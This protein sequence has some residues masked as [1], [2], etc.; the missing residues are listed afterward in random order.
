MDVI[1]G[2]KDETGRLQIQLERYT[3]DNDMLRRDLEQREDTI[4]VLRSKLTS[5]QRELD[6]MNQNLAKDEEE[7]REK[8]E[9]VRALRSR[10]T[11]LEQEL[12]TLNAEKNNAL[13]DGD[14]LRK[15]KEHADEQ[16]ESIRNQSFKARADV[17]TSEVAKQRLQSLYEGAVK[18]TEFLKKDNKALE[19][20]LYKLKRDVLDSET[21]CNE[22]FNQ[23]KIAQE[24]EKGLEREIELTQEKFSNKLEE[25][26]KIDNIRLETERANFDLQNQNQSLKEQIARDKKLREDIGSHETERVRLLRRIDELELLLKDKAEQIV[27]ITEMADKERDEKLRLEGKMDRLLNETSSIE[28]NIQRARE[29]EAEYD[30]LL[31]ELDM[32]KEKEHGLIKENEKLLVDNKRH[33]NLIANGT[34]QIEHVNLQKEELQREIRGLKE[35]VSLY[36]STDNEAK[37]RSI[38]L[39]EKLNNHDIL[40]ADLRDSKATEERKNV[41]LSD[42]ITNL[43][44]D[45]AQEKSKNEQLTEQIKQLKTL[46]EGLDRTREELLVRLQNKNNER[47]IEES[48]R[49]RL[50]EEINGLKRRLAAAEQDTK[51]SRMAMTEIDRER[52]A[53]QNLLDEKS[54]S[55]EKLR[56]RIES[57]E[58]ELRTMKEKSVEFMAMTDEGNYRVQ[59]QESQLRE[60][61]KKNRTLNEEVNEYRNAI[62]VKD[63][64]IQSLSDDLNILTRENQNQNQR[65]MQV[66]EEKEGLKDALNN[67][68]GQEKVSRQSLRATEMERNDILS[69]YKSV[70]MENERLKANIS[71]LSADSHSLW[72]KVKEAEQQSTFYKGQAQ[73]LESKEAQYLNE[74][75]TYERQ[76]THLNYRLEQAEQAIRESQESKENLI[77]E[78]HSIRQVRLQQLMWIHK[79]LIDV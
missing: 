26:R 21:K 67:V 28:V 44:Q 55:Y 14:R 45:L 25:C 29:R 11:E 20:Q 19:E 61:M 73:Q 27:S 40:I 39:Q 4:S 53:I 22:Y 31:K 8:G 68:S 62:A 70:C 42:E 17:D 75:G 51:E 36:K 65:M 59:E 18:D 1:D 46:S 56:D 77:R 52:D 6:M 2:Y 33:E 32:L 54:E 41:R 79:L 43:K 50:Q 38:K 74:I 57:Q 63:R 47:G 16:L 5:M 23:L 35:E 34:R 49:L 15:L 72:K 9:V 3:T 66:V 69:T 13:L 10:I 60:M 30:R 12:L 24:K 58:E 76:V 7:V 64:E 71:E 78:F 48:E 37:T